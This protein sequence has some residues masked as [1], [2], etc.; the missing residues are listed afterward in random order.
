[1]SRRRCCCGGTCTNGNCASVVTA[2]ATSGFIIPSVRIS[3]SVRIP[4]CYQPNC[5]TYDGGPGGSYEAVGPTGCI[6]CWPQYINY[7]DCVPCRDDLLL[8]DS[9]WGNSNITYTPADPRTFNLT[10]DY[11]WNE[12]WYAVDRNCGPG[13]PEF[14]CYDGT[15]LV[16][17]GCAFLQYKSVSRSHTFGPGSWKLCGGGNASSPV[18]SI[19]AYYGELCGGCSDQPQPCCCDDCTDCEQIRCDFI[20]MEG[21]TPIKQGRMRGRI[22]QMI[23][24]SGPTFNPSQWWCGAGCSGNPEDNGYSRITVELLADIPTTAINANNIFQCDGSLIPNSPGRVTLPRALSFAQ[25][26]LADADGEFW[27]VTQGSVIATFRKCRNSVDSLANKCQMEKGI[28]E[29]VYVGPPG[30][31]AIP[32]NDCITIDGTPCNVK[33]MMDLLNRIGWGI[34]V[35]VL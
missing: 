18:V 16:E 34:T 25:L 31:C 23:P 20:F 35:E 8:G 14:K 10:C 22:L 4:G 28:Y 17:A 9:Y 32:S 3:A 27:C 2:C 7:P 1:V 13:S 11:R 26:G 24:C 6:R 19:A 30:T 15:T 12:G 5:D 33:E 29:L 21:N